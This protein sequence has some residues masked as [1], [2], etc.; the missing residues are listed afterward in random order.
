M[1]QPDNSENPKPSTSRIQALDCIV[2][3]QGVEEQESG[4]LVVLGRADGVHEEE[5]QYDERSC[6]CL[7]EILA[8]P[9][10]LLEIELVDHSL[11]E[12]DSVVVDHH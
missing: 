2:T 7:A 6:H 1:H 8:S 4:L 5:C 12:E 10:H 9:H 11:T 3:V